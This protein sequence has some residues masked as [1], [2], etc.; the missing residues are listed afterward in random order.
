MLVYRICLITVICLASWLVDAGSSSETSPKLDSVPESTT[1]SLPKPQHH[2]GPCY[3]A[4]QAGTYGPTVGPDGKA[5]DYGPK[6]E[7]KF[8][9]DPSTQVPG[10]AVWG[11]PSITLSNGTQC[12]DNLS[13]VSHGPSQKTSPVLVQYR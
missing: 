2:N 3:Q 4:S 8:G 11:R 7:A 10:T 13:Q 6:E 9:R 12:C 5:L 1:L